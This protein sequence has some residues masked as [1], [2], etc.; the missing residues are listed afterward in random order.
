MY[1]CG[2]SLPENSL[3]SPDAR[4]GKISTTR[5][6]GLPLYDLTF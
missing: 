5:S 6:E 4:E 3:L 1:P 2:I